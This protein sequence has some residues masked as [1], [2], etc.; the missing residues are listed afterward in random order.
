MTSLERVRKA[1]H[2]DSPDRMPHYLPDGKENDILWLWPTMPVR[3]G[4]T[5]EADGKERKI[6]AW[7]TVYERMSG[8]ALD[9]GQKCK[10]AIPDITR[11]EECVFPDFLKPEYF[12]GNRERIRANSDK[13]CLGVMPY[14]SLN[15][16]VHNLTEL[17][18]MFCAYYESPQK[19]KS[20]IQR[21]ADAQMQSIRI[22]ADIGCH[23]VMAY[24]DWGL[25]DRQMVSDELIEEFFMPVYRRNWGYAHEL[26]MEVWMHSCGY[27]LD[28]LPR[29]HEWG[30]D[31][32]QLDQQ[33]NMGLDALNEKVGGRLAFWCPVDIQKTMITGTPDDVR[34]YVRKLRATLGDHNGGLISMAYST[35]AAVAHSPANLAA[36]CDEFRNSRSY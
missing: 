20:L 3:Q 28:L 35:P 17:D 34:T 6:N 9:H 36:M 27:V 32:I 11:H 21:L 7:G 4:W 15:E 1:I 30:L 24:D 5:L 31:V 33:E 22:L 25:Q 26:G 12:T 18:Q 29:F 16:G 10:I 19:L 23:G 14:S 8:T 2:F 13:Y